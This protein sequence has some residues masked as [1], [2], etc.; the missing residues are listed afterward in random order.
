MKRTALVL[1]TAS[2][3]AACV[4]SSSLDQVR[5]GMS[6]EQ[7]TSIMGVAD[8]S[9]YTA[10]N[11]CAVYTVMKDFWMRVPWDMTNRYYVCYNEGKVDH[12]GRA[13]QPVPSDR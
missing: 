11:D 5:P 1:L 10:G 12:F 8:S 4:Q 9:A 3:A 13:D 2:A 7:V 6:R